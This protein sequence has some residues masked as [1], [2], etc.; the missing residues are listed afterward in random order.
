M[1]FLGEASSSFSP[2]KPQSSPPAK[3]SPYTLHTQPPLLPLLYPHPDFR[4]CSFARAIVLL[5]FFSFS[6][7]PFAQKHLGIAPAQNPRGRPRGR[8]RRP[9]EAGRVYARIKQPS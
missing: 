1:T 8:F 3:D 9:E 2:R 4:A 7:T 6:P 5:L